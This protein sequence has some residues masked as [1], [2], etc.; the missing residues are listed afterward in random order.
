MLKQTH[1]NAT[2]DFTKWGDDIY[3]LRVPVHQSIK[4]L[5]LNLTETLD[6]DRKEKSIYALKIPMKNLLL[7]DDDSLIDYP[8]VDGDILIVL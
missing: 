5:I 1:I 6:I 4:Q 8:V 7:A 3:D 2:I